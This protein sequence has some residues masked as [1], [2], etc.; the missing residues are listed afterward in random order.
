L[1]S[2]TSPLIITP[3]PDGINFKLIQEF[4][5]DVG[6]LGSGDTIHVPADFITDFASIPQTLICLIGLAAMFAAA[7]LGLWLSI[8]GAIIIFL[9]VRLPNFG[10]YGKAAVLHDYLY[11]THGRTRHEADDIFK[12]AMLVSCVS[13]WEAVMMWAAVRLFGSWAYWKGVKW[14]R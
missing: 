13:T 3:E 5:Y 4:D 2:F 12:E 14:L 9:V 11:L 8:V 10:K 7:W 6:V 1:S